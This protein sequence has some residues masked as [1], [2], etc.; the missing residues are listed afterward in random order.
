M[1]LLRFAFGVLTLGAVAYA[2]GGFVDGLYQTGRWHDGPVSGAVR[3]D[4]RPSGG[5]THVS[6]ERRVTPSKVL[7]Y[8]RDNGNT[9]F[10][11]DARHA[12]PC[13]PG[14]L[15]L[16]GR[17]IAGSS[18]G[19]DA[20]GSLDLR[21][22][23]HLELEAAD[24]LRAAAFFGTTRQDRRPIGESARARFVVDRAI[25][26]VGDPIEV[27]VELESSGAP[28]RYRRGGRNRGPRDDQ[29]DFEVR[30]EGVVLPRV[31]A[32]NLGGLSTFVPLGPGAAATVRT[33]LAPW[34]D[35]SAPGRYEVRCRYETEL[36]PFEG[37]PYADDARGRVWDRV[38]EGVVRFEIR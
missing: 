2:Q 22:S 33:P 6:I 24:A 25:Y 27:R 36:V 12:P 38:F 14:L 26:A 31:E 32:W 15:M 37:E 1:R 29:F 9:R 8:A 23:T 3:V 7:I 18:F 16:G 13:G 11:F 21:C 19:S 4:V 28:V 17:A 30:R 20:S 35:L 34:A 5:G 10:A